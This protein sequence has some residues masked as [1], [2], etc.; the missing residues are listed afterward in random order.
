MQCQNV[1]PENCQML[2]QFYTMSPCLPTPDATEPNERVAI[3]SRCDSQQ[4]FPL[5]SHK[6][7]VSTLDHSS[8]CVGEKNLEIFFATSKFFRDFPFLFPF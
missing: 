3:G 1:R 5:Q 2:T 8:T 4:A 6:L 7:K